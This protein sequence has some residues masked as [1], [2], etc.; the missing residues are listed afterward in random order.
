MPRMCVFPDHAWGYAGM[1][2][3]HFKGGAFETFSPLSLITSCK[4]SFLPHHLLFSI[5]Q[6]PG[7]VRIHWQSCVH[8]CVWLLVC[9][10][11]IHFVLFFCTYHS[12]HSCA[13]SSPSQLGCRALFFTDH[14]DHTLVLHSLLSPCCCCAAVTIF[15]SQICFLLDLLFHHLSLGSLCKRKERCLFQSSLARRWL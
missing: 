5:P 4:E 6:I 14:S 8:H 15:P 7:H 3:L 9:H 13:S 11:L 12:Q 10:M 1:L 2:Y